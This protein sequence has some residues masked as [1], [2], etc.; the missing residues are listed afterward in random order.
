MGSNWTLPSS[1]TPSLRMIER[2][3]EAD[4]LEYMA[5][6]GSAAPADAVALMAAGGM[7]PDAWQADLLRSGWHRALLL[8]SRQSGKS[9]VTAALATWTALYQPDSLTL[10]LS[11]SQRQSQELFAKVKGFYLSL[12]IAVADD[13]VGALS[14]RLT[15]GSRVIALPGKE[16]TIRGFSGVDLLVIDEAARVDDALYA[17]VR[18]MLAVSGGRLIALSTPFGNRG[19]FYEAWRGEEAWERH[20]IVA[21]QCPRIPAAFLEEERRTLG[22]W[23]YSQEYECVFQDAIGAAFRTEDIE[24]LFPITGV[25]QWEL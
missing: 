11:P 23:W 13:S 1:I 15:N 6:G 12:G 18:P 19:W 3:P 14:L 5:R 24:K 21:S 22:G 4:R 25:T 17:S 20:K 10:L 16:Q 2:W 8:C 9:T 7:Q